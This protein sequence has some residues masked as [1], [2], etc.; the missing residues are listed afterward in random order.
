MKPATWARVRELFHVAGELSPDERREFLD[1]SRVD[2]EVRD[3]LERLLAEDASSND[4][5][6][7][8]TPAPEPRRAPLSPGRRIGRYE[9]VR[10]LATG[11]MGTV[12]EAVQEEPRRRVALKTLRVGFRTAEDRRR[13]QF[14]V[15]ILGRL[16]HA[17]IAQIHEAGTHGEDGADTPYFAMELIE[18]ARDV[19]TYVREEGL[20]LR[21]KL[22]VFLELCNAVQYGHQ[23]GVVHRDLKPDNV[24]VDRAG[25]LA[26][27]DFGVAR[28]TDSDV[29][30][31]TQSGR[32]VGTVLYMSPEQLSGDPAAIDTRADVYALGALLYELTCGAPIFDLAQRSVPDMIRTAAED[33]PR[34]LSQVDSS[35]AGDLEWIANKALERDKERRYG[36]VAELAAEVSRHL[37]HEPVLAGPPATTYRLGRFLRRNRTVVGAL[38]AVFLSLAAGLGWALVER[39]RAVEAREGESNQRELAIARAEEADEARELAQERALEANLARGEEARQRAAAEEA[40]ARADR[41]SRLAMVSEIFLDELFDGL[42]PGLTGGRELTV[43]EVFETTL[44]TI[45]RLTAAGEVWPPA[46][47][48]FRES[49]AET[50]LRMGD[51]PAAEAQARIS[52][53]VRLAEFGPEHRETLKSAMILAHALFRQ[54]RTVE[55]EPFVRS[56]YESAYRTRGPE[57]DTTI[58]FTTML[59]RVLVESDRLGEAEL[60]LRDAVDVTRRVFDEEPSERR[61]VNHMNALGN[62][63]WALEEAGELEEAAFWAREEL[64]IGSELL[65]P[66]HSAVLESQ[67]LLARVQ[68]ARG[69]LEEARSLLED[70]F[71]R[72]LE[73]YG[74]T[75]PRTLSAAH[76]LVTFYEET[77]DEE[78]AGRF[79]E[80]HGAKR[81]SED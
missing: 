4:V 48:E 71:D 3:E 81:P 66:Y 59:A 14:E 10:I 29:A 74:P 24:L 80:E 43:R 36:S 39:N 49:V 44:Q 16:R 60:L 50:Y 19:M 26:V 33:T 22:E 64:T 8:G 54:N 56:S 58:E 69:E 34:R 5:M 47:A 23:Q 25:R 30:L 28:A 52:Y 18:G 40:F 6:G 32:I 27:I 73:A 12:Y 17:G 35:L 68:R 65:P 37:A 51:F 55:A 46:I 67:A 15:E 7:Q 13:F 75:H 78:A 1:T 9:I 11:G 41:R 72:R 57:D 63:G 38:V 79:L 2:A 62:L 76:G 42:D 77:G 31:T 21:Q 45:D 53:D 61:L 70:N 20:T